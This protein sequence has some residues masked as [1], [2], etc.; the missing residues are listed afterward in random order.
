M[1]SFIGQVP[2][3]FSLASKPPGSVENLLHTQNYQTSGDSRGVNGNMASGLQPFQ[4]GLT[5]HIVRHSSVENVSTGNYGTVGNT[6]DMNGNMLLAMQPGMVWM[7][8]DGMGWDGMGWDGM[9]WD[10]NR[11]IKLTRKKLKRKTSGKITKKSTH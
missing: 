1:D 7:G 4:N 9:G 2:S 11:R 5:E 8:W 3:H 6:R 10:R